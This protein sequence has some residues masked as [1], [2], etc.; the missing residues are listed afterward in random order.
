MGVWRAL[1]FSDAVKRLGD[2]SLF[3]K[4]TLKDVAIA[5]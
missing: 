1:R 5:R 2:L 3:R 4:V